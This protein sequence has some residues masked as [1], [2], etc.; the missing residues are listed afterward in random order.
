MIVELTE[1]EEKELK[2]SYRKRYEARLADGYWPPKYTFE[3]YYRE[4]REFKPELAIDPKYGVK[5][6]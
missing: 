2:E 4:C 6:E 3:D 1:E 5:K